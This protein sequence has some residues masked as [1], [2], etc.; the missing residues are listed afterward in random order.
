M[1]G[2]VTYETESRSREGMATPAQWNQTKN[3]EPLKQPLRQR[4]QG[5]LLKFTMQR[6]WT[7]SYKSKTIIGFEPLEETINHFHSVFFTYKR[8]QTINHDT[9]DSHYSIAN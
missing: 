8:T 4:Q 1:I 3:Q 7:S 9:K 5:N 6:Q 2:K